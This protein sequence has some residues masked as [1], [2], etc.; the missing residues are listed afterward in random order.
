MSSDWKGTKRILNEVQALFAQEDDL[1]ELNEI[2]KMRA[3]IEAH[4]TAASKDAKE[5]IK[6]FTTKV[7]EKEKEIMAPS[8]IAHAIEIEKVRTDKENAAEQVQNLQNSLDTK[9]DKISDFAEQALKLM[10]QCAETNTN[11][12]LAD[13][14][15]AYAL[16]LYAKISNISWDYKAP[17]G[18]LAGTIGNEETSTLQRFEMDTRNKTS[19]EMANGLW[20]MISASVA[21]E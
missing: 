14:R 2:F 21:D 13:S 10:K 8:E 3:E 4:C 5:L 11:S 19:F 1:K 6:D 7:T 17:S 12:Q 9:R 16:S 20:D 18:K 15:T